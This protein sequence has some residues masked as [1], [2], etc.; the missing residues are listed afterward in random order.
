MKVRTALL[1][2]T[3][4]PND[5]VLY[6]LD[7]VTRYQLLDE[8]IKREFE[9]YPVQPNYRS[10]LNIKPLWCRECGGL[11]FNRKH[12]DLMHKAF[13]LGF[14]KPDY[15][16]I[17]CS[18]ADFVSRHYF[19]IWDLPYGNVMERHIMYWGASLRCRR[20]ISDLQKLSDA[21]L[22]SAYE[23]LLAEAKCRKIIVSYNM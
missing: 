5:V 7:Y 19:D 14:F 17:A 20:M 22:K 16:C 8:D 21:D 15:T 23:K 4:V 9:A 6:I 18:Q 3:I 12:H 2:L 11:A 10:I 1:L 13:K